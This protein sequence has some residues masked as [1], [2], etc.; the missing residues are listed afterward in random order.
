MVWQLTHQK[1]IIMHQKI[2]AM[3]FG[4]T[5]KCGVKQGS[6]VANGHKR[7]GKVNEVH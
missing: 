5:K 1:E 4:T 2:Q 6:K 7:G 3:D